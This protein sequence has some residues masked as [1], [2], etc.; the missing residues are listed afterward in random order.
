M[1]SYDAFP[2]QEFS[3]YGEVGVRLVAEMI[4]NFTHLENSINSLGNVEFFSA[5]R[6][7]KDSF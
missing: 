1:Q 7:M 5:G 6:F 3:K 2:I 4:D